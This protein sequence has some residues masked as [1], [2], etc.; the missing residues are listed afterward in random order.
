MSDPRLVQSVAE[1][2]RAAAVA[3]ALS[4]RVALV[5]T[6][7][8]L[9]AGHVR[10]L[11]EARKAAD[12]VVLSIFVNP[13]Q[14]GPS[15]DLA[16]YPRT[17][18]ADLDK[19]RAAGVDVVFHPDGNAMYPEGYQT[20]VQV[21]ALEKGLCGDRRPGHFI[22]VATVVLKLFH[23]VQP[24]VAFFGEKDWQ[25]L[26]VIRRMVHDLDVP[27]MVVGVPIVREP[28]GLAM[29]SRNAYL[30]PD[31]RALA[32]SLSRALFAARARFQAGERDAAA[33]VGA[34]RAIVDDAKGVRLD[35]LE[36]RHAET[37]EPLDG[38]VAGPAVLAVAA[39]VGAT[40]LIDNFTLTA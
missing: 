16:R 19:A 6:M 11:E 12:V 31:E 37:L 21:R 2:R 27:V 5:P 35:Y 33:L 34:A 24:Q 28:D 30:S 7:G 36:L 26:Q 8:A 39:F 4:R 13:T 14:F 32:L 10:L 40:R 22:G 9:H 1:M 25:Q 23:I 18:A 38:R 17:L 29:S 15:E 20:Y 3:H